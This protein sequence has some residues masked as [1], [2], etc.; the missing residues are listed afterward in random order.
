MHKSSVKTGKLSENNHSKTVSH[1]LCN[2]LSAAQEHNSNYTIIP[3]L[4]VLRL[5]GKR[6]EL[7]HEIMHHNHATFLLN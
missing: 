3:R 1:A 2:N 6:Q 7:F 5:K 4:E